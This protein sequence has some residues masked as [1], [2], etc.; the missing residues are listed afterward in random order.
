MG[1]SGEIGRVGAMDAASS[2]CESQVNVCASGLCTLC[3]L[4]LAGMKVTGYSREKTLAIIRRVRSDAG[5]RDVDR[6][7]RNVDND[8]RVGEHET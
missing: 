7:L 3:E 4:A 2:N 6:T 1:P 8:L 5:P